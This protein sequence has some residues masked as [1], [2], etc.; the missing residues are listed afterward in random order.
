MA[1]SS[2]WKAVRTPARPAMLAPAPL[3][4]EKLMTPPL[5]VTPPLRLIL[6]ALLTVTVPPPLSLMPVMVNGAAPLVRLILP[7][8]LLLALKLATVFGARSTSCP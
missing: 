7:L 1:T 2:A 3:A 5:T 4:V 8:V 6:P